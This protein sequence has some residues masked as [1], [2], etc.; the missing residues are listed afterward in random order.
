MASTP[1]TARSTRR[2]DQLQKRVH[3]KRVAKL[4]PPGGPLSER[5][6]CK[7]ASPLALTTRGKVNLLSWQLGNA[8]F[9][10]YRSRFKV[11]PL[12]AAS[13]P[14]SQQP[15]GHSHAREAQV[16]REKGLPRHSPSE[17]ACT[18]SCASRSKLDVGKTKRQ[19]PPCFASLRPLLVLRQSF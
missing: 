11:F 4:A 8:G 16:S 15:T 19:A 5:S 10:L 9:S 12:L 13:E 18:A 6:S 3:D 7:T 1:P 17:S 2:H 14:G